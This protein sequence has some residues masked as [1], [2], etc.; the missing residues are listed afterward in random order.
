MICVDRSRAETTRR[1]QRVLNNEW[2]CHQSSATVAA[3]SVSRRTARIRLT[4]AGIA[5]RRRD[6]IE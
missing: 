5:R 3:G 2:M 4:E 6:A 1:V